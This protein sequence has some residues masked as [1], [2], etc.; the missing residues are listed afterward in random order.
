M[1]NVLPFKAVAPAVFAPSP[2]QQ[3][4]FD[5]ID[6][7]TG[8]A[9]VKAVAGAGKTTTII[10]A[11]KRIP[12]IKQNGRKVSILMLA[13]NKDIAEELKTRVPE[14]VSAKTF[15]SLGLGALAKHYGNGIFKRIDDRKVLKIM[16]RHFSPIDYKLYK[17]FVNTL[18]DLAKQAGIGY[19]EDDKP[20]AWQNLVSHYDVELETEGLMDDRG[21]YVA[22]TPEKGIALARDIL[23]LSCAQ[24]ADAIDYNDMIYMPL[25]L[26]LRLWGNDWVF[27][28]EAQDLNPTRRALAKKVLVPG[29]RLIAVGDP[30]QAIYGFT[31]AS[32]DSLERIARD[33]NCIELPLTVS[34]RCPQAVVRA[35]Q[36]FVPYIQAHE[37]APEGIVRAGNG[38]ERFEATD[39]IICRNTAPLVS[40]AYGLIAAGV[41]CRILGR[42]IGEGLIV[43]IDK[44]KAKGVDALREKLEAWRDREVEV[45]M[46]KGQEQK[47]D[48]ICDRVAA[49]LTLIDR[50]PETRRTIPA[51][52]DQ[53]KSMFE[54]KTKG[55]LTLCTAHKSKGQ[56]WDRVF[57]LGRDELMPSK[58]ARQA[59]QLDQENNLI[60]VAFTRAKRELVFLPLDEKTADQKAA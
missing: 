17:S 53:I 22:A 27:V 50:L 41:G 7:G 31:G 12:A 45:A 42:D 33:F 44:Q 59:W 4:V 1:S 54:D 60:Y 18:V 32:S 13:Y 56:E 28:D 15:H 5:F 38:V 43:L 26:G 9:I 14:H 48:S 30:C 20:Q 3:A 8:S 37:G 21:R 10:Q 36:S 35:A 19:L 47:A 52:K 16:E 6:R 34:Y 11:L 57:L 2:A 55:V 25:V 24:C 49:I 29:G 51:I 40:M 23:A 58:F 46:G 39:A